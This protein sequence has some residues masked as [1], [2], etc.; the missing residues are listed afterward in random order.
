MIPDSHHLTA[1]PRGETLGQIYLAEPLPNSILKKQRVVLSHYILNGLIT[2]N[3]RNKG[4]KGRNKEEMD[5]LKIMDN[6]N[7]TN[8]VSKCSI[9][10]I[11]IQD[12]I[13]TAEVDKTKGKTS[14]IHNHD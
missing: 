11:K 8:Y 1:T 5:K 13:H 6:P 4:K 9:G 12:K 3:R 7:I 2:K 10:K 14:Q